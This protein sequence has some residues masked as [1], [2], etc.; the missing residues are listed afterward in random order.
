MG[1]NRSRASFVNEYVKPFPGMKILDV[2]CGPADILAYLPDT[3]YWGF[4]VSEVYITQAQKKYDD[5]GIFHLK[6]LEFSDLAG[7][8]SF[9]LVLAIGLLHHLDDDE[10]KEFMQLASKAL[11]SKGRL[12]TIDPCFDE[13]QNPVAR[14]LVRNDRGQNVR[15]KSGYEELAQSTFTDLNVVV[16]NRFWIPYTHCIMECRS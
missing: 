10:V 6:Q 7:L 2:G 11:I 15:D 1:A 3:E 4:D 5:R 13:S 16:R 8:P 14:F 12:V 9:D